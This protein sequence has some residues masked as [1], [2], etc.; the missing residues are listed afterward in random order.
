ME[1]K[2]YNSAQKLKD[3]ASPRKWVS[4]VRELLQEVLELG[5]TLKWAQCGKL[6]VR[7]LSERS[8]TFSQTL[9]P[10][11]NTTGV[12]DTDDCAVEL[13]AMLA[14][15]EKGCD[16]LETSEMATNIR[17]SMADRSSKGSKQCSFGLECF[18]R[19]CSFVHP[20]GGIRRL[21]PSV[22]GQS[23]MAG[24]VPQVNTL[25]KAVVVKVV[26]QSFVTL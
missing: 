24:R 3:G 18:R 13:D 16:E 23:A 6:F 20:A 25:A 19:D 2:V 17:A 10:F 12:V 14:L 8:N 26:V 21:R 7:M 15:V 5:V 11:S 22:L 1:A 9:L 4:D